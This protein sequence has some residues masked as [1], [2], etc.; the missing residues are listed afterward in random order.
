SGTFDQESGGEVPSPG[1][2][3][4]AAWVNSIGI[5]PPSGKAVVLRTIGGAPCA[6]ATAVTPNVM[7]SARCEARRIVTFLQNGENAY[8]RPKVLVAISEARAFFQGRRKLHAPYPQVTAYLRVGYE[9]DSGRPRNSR[10]RLWLPDRRTPDVATA[11]PPSARI[12]RAPARPAGAG[13][14]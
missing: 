6:C 7:S 3:P 9:A 5:T 14:R 1:A 10:Q 12:P 11:R 13:K 2:A 4:G 8:E